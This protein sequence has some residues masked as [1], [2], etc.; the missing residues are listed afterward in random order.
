M[1][2]QVLDLAI[3]GSGLSALNFADEYSKNLKKK[4]TLFLTKMKRH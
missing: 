4:L 2:K 1:K 3:I